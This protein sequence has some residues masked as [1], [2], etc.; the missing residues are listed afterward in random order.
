[1][2]AHLSG[3]RRNRHSRALDQGQ[4]QAPDR[5]IETP[6]LDDQL[7]AWWH[8]ARVNAAAAR[9][10]GPLLGPHPDRPQH[11][12]AAAAAAGQ[13]RGRAGDRHRLTGWATA[14]P[15]S[16]S[17]AARC[18]TT[19][20]CRSTAPTT[21][22]TASSSPSDKLRVAARRRLRRARAHGGR[23]RDP[24]R[25]HRPPPPRRAATRSRPGSS[26]SPTRS[27]WP[28]GR[29]RIPF[30]AGQKKIH[31]LSARGDRR[32]EDRGRGDEPRSGSRSR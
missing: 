16:S 27:T 10:V 24:A 31:S 11:R 28:Q 7:K 29:S 3:D 12:A 26:A 30:E 21:R 6:M 32:G 13:A 5:L 19:S 22:P 23:R 18:C 14:T 15:R 4:S 8:V 25:D 1:M 2:N 20:A 9:D 17:P